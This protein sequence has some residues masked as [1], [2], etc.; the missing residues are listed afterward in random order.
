LKRGGSENRILLKKDK[1]YVLHPGDELAL[2]VTLYSL[3]LK[4]K[5]KIPPEECSN[6]LF[7]SNRLESHPSGD[8]IEKIHETW[9]GDYDLLEKHHGYIQW[10]FPIFEGKGMNTKSKRLK[11]DEAALMRKD[12]S[13]AKRVIMSYRSHTPFLFL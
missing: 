13:I 10:L 11:K 7:Y 5:E 4:V 9:I 1:D 6:Y 8:L 3:K 12:L 2:L